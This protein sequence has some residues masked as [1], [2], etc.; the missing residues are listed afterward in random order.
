MKLKMRQSPAKWTDRL[1]VLALGGLGLAEIWIFVGLYPVNT[2][3]ANIFLCLIASLTLLWRRRAPVAVLFI[4]VAVLGI[5]A[6]FF[7][8]TGEPPLTTFVLLLVVFY[9][10]AAHGEGRRADVGAAVAFAAEILAID[11]PR[12]LAGENLGEIIPAWVFIIV[13]WFVGKTIRQRR[14]QAVELEDRASQLELERE[15]KARLAV[16]EERSRISRELHDVIAHSV[17]VMVV[18]SQAAQRLLEG[19]QRNA[20]QAL[21]SIETTGRQA[22]TEMRRLLGILRRTDAELALAPQPSLEH[23]NTLIEQMREAG[24]PVELCIEGEVEPLSPGVDL[25]AYRIVQ[26]ALTNTLKHAGPAR[27]RVEI[28]YRDDEVELEISDD[29]RGTGRGGGSGQGLIGMHERVALYGGVLESGERDTGGYLVRARLP[30]DS[31]Q[32]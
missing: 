18:Q 28:H 15:E 13:F 14:L 3:L 10:V 4:C 5:Q 25:S 8:P 12:F 1:I 19:E 16:T 27:A 23:L 22:L 11:V 31:D 32:P 26:E 20:R 7:N 30:L 21:K 24:L 17:S 6:N 29:G 2:F 9:S